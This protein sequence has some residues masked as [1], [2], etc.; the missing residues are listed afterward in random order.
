VRPSRTGEHGPLYATNARPTTPGGRFAVVAALLLVLS[1]CTSDHPAAITAPLTTASVAAPVLGAA[2]P[3]AAAAAPT[4]GPS[5]VASAAPVTIPGAVTG[6]PVSTNAAIVAENSRRGTAEW[7]IAPSGS[8]RIEGYADTTSA[9]RGDIVSLYVSTASATWYV[10]AY[11]MGWYGGDMGREVWRSPPVVGRVQGPPTVN[12]ATHTA[13]ARWSPASSA[14]A[15]TSVGSPAGFGI[16]K[17]QKFDRSSACD[18]T[19]Y[20]L[21]PRSSR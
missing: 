1:A 14:W 15:F 7:R 16:E 8:G 12:P 21:I 4:S 3:A 20:S 2:T 19:N 11:R 5:P 18:A 10:T 9:R 13:E 17:V 6:G